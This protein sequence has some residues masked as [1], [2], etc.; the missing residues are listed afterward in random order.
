MIIDK[1]LIYNEIEAEWMSQYM[2]YCE[3][4]CEM[5]M[6]EDNNRYDNQ[7]IMTNDDQY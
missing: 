3:W 2:K 5:R 7:L 4:E 1:I 6:N